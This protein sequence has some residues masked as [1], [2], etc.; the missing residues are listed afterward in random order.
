M[1]NQETKTINIITS[2]SVTVQDMINSIIELDNHVIN[3][4]EETAVD[5]LHR[6]KDSRILFLKNIHDINVNT[7]IQFSFQTE[8]QNKLTDKDW[9]K[10]RLPHL[11]SSIDSHS[12]I[13]KYAFHKN[14][15]I[16]NQ[17]LDNLILNYFF[18]FE[19]KVRNIVR[20]IKN[21]ENPY[22]NPKSKKSNPYLN[23]SEPFGAIRKGLFENHLNLTNEDYEV[24][25]IY[26]AIRNTIHNSGF[27]FSPDSKNSNYT[28][29]TINYVFEHGKPIS[30]FAMEMKFNMMKDLLTLFE[31]IINHNKVKKIEKVNDLSAEVEFQ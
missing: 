31:N 1:I 13:S 8:S 5:K 28:Y 4:L 17:I 10:K 23:G 2:E 11:S 18:E 27:Y 19:T 24:I 6:N 20:S 25:G 22:Y 7:I 29:R 21:L 30:F 9:L 12:D 14:R 26:S 15:H 16:F 3:V